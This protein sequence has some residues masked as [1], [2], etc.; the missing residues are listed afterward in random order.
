MQGQNMLP[1]DFL[2]VS[3]SALWGFFFQCPSCL[4]TSLYR[5]S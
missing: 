3:Q 5:S 4:Q 2:V 1:G